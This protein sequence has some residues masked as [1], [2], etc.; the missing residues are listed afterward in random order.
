M[1]NVCDDI[2]STSLTVNLQQVCIN[3][4]DEVVL[5]R[6]FNYLMEEVGRQQL[7]NVGPREVT[8]E[9]LRNASDS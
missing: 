4:H 8:R 6:S 9:R 2:K 7:M 3:P 5:E 1:I